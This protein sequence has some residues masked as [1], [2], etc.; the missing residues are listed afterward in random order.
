MIPLEVGEFD[1]AGEEVV[2]GDRVAG[3]GHVRTFAIDDT[4]IRHDF[5]EQ[6]LATTAEEVL[7]ADV[8]GARLRVALDESLQG[9]GEDLGLQEGVRA[10]RRRLLQAL[11]DA[12][13]RLPG[14]GQDVEVEH[15]VVAAGV[16]DRGRR[17]LEARLRLGEDVRLARFLVGHAVLVAADDATLDQAIELATRLGQTVG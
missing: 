7:V 6:A 16:P 8:V 9:S 5:E 17:V 13:R 1:L 12:G 14:A 2:E 10:D 3:V 11:A 4:A 15:G